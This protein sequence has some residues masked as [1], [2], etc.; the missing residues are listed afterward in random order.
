M[1]SFQYD[2]YYNYEEMKEFLLEMQK[3]YHEICKLEELAETDGGHIIWGVTLAAGD[4]VMYPPEKR[5][6]LY[7]RVGFILQK[8]WV[9]QRHLPQ[10][11]ASLLSLMQ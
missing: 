1:K 7:I 5:P 10:C 4:T 6:A 11:I 3:Q 8:A 9:S 2:R